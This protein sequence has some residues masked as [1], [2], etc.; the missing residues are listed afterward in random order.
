DHWGDKLRDS[1]K[2]LPWAN[3]NAIR[4]RFT[5]NANASTVLPPGALLRQEVRQRLAGLGKSAVL[6][7]IKIECATAASAA[8]LLADEEQLF[9]DIVGCWKSNPESLQ[10]TLKGD[11]DIIALTRRLRRSFPNDYEVEAMIKNIDNIDSVI[12]VLRGKAQS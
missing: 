1:V 11:D 8:G 12:Q 9:A 7:K 4:I 2:H 6:E 10:S 3:A 5:G